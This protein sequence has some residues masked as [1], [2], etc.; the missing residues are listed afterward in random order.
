M[1]EHPNQ[2]QQGV[3]PTIGVSQAWPAG[4]DWRLLVT[5]GVMAVTGLLLLAL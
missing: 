1:S 4:T 5:Y 3:G 2:I